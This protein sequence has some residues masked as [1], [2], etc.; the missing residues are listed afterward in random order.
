VGP[1]AHRW[2]LWI[3]LRSGSPAVFVP[4]SSAPPPGRRPSAHPISAKGAPARRAPATLVSAAPA[5][6]ARL[7]RTLTPLREPK[8]ASPSMPIDW[9]AMGQGEFGPARRGPTPRSMG[10]AMGR[11]ALG[12]RKARVVAQSS[13]PASRWRFGTARLAPAQLGLRQSPGTLARSPRT[14]GRRRTLKPGSADPEAMH[15]LGRWSVC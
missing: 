3:A 10:Q 8:A 9:M 14:K 4:S 12:F 1:R 6:G 11:R 7:T 13:G 15:S 2:S 5:L